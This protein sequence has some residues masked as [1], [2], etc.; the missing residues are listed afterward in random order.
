MKNIDFLPPRYKARRQ[1]RR[2]FV[3]QVAAGASFAVLVAVAAAWQFSERWQVAS[4]LAAL[5]PQH[6]QALTTQALHE[7][8]QTRLA[9]ASEA[10]ELFMYLEHPWPR[11]QVLH[12][13]E[14]CLPQDLSLTDVHL[15]YEAMP[16]PAPPLDEAEQAKLTPTQRDLARLRREMDRRAAVIWIS[17]TTG[18]AGHIYEFT[19]RLGQSPLFAAIKLE[20]AENQPTAAIKQT[21]FRLR[22]TL[23]PGYGQPGG[24]HAAQVAEQKP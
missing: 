14:S 18:D 2:T 20:N 4:Q 9:A 15:T 13:I 5:G 6:Q 10:A 19:D 7:Q 22:G 24:P 21:N 8:L 17:G 11:T 3:W 16:V 1:E 23:K 12:A